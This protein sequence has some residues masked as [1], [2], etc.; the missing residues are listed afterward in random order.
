MQVL[1]AHTETDYQ[2]ILSIGLSSIIAYG[3]TKRQSDALIE[4]FHA[5]L[6]LPAPPIF[7]LSS[8]SPSALP[9]V[10]ELR[11]RPISAPTSSRSFSPPPSVETIEV[12][13]R[14]YKPTAQ[15]QAD[16]KEA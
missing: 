13:Q 14:I 9:V 15:Y 16:E 3:F 6:A 1:I 4:L 5:V 12:E 7:T 11:P 2:A 8:A 10:P